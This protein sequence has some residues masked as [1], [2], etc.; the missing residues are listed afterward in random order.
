MYPNGDCLACTF[1]NGKVAETDGNINAA[2]SW[3]DGERFT[4]WFKYGKPEKGILRAADG[5]EK[6]YAV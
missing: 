2:Y 5:Q 3:K 1:N 4:G 6:E